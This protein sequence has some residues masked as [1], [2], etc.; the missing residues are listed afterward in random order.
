MTLNPRKLRKRYDSQ[1]CG[2]LRHENYLTALRHAARLRSFH[3]NDSFSVYHCD[4]C[5]GLHVGHRNK[6]L[7]EQDLILVS[8]VEAL[9]GGQQ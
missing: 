7:P 9:N 8:S 3:P 6:T 2:K 5:T 4:F 1:C